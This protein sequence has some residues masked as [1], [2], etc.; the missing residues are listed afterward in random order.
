MK[1]PQGLGGGFTHGK[2]SPK[3]R[4][5]DGDLLW[6]FLYLDVMRQ[7]DIARDLNSSRKQIIDDLKNISFTTSF[8]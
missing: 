1:I 8:F 6:H 7:N 5:L 4:V 3:N 2:S